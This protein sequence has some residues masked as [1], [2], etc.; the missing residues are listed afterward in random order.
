MIDKRIGR[1]LLAVFS[2][3]AASLAAA[4]PPAE[5]LAAELRR[6][7]AGFDAAVG[8]A[9]ILDGRDTVVIGGAADYP[10][11]SVVK[12]PQAMAVVD[13]L[14][15]SGQPLAT[16]LRIAPEEL[17]PDTWSPLRDSLPQ[18]GTMTVAELL[19]FTLQRSDNNACDILFDRF[20]GPEAV[21]RYLR[22]LGIGGDFAV[23]VTEAGMHRDPAAC[24]RNRTSPLAAAAW[25]ECLLTRKLFTPAGRRFLVETLFG[26]RTGADRLPQPL[27][28]TGARIGHK[29][30]TGD[31]RPDGRMIGCND[32]GFVVLPDGRHYTIAVLIRDSAESDAANARLIAEI[33]AIVYRYAAEHPRRC[34]GGRKKSIG[35]RPKK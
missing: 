29:T 18:G 5:R 22:G 7:T 14:E 1:L 21:D 34:G 27:A 15:R 3:A 19:R 23:A 35:N 28:D 32:V 20:G 25:T 4:C 26:C 31:R 16:P 8:V 2:L 24:Y 13:T 12:L 9:V 10:M 33:S 6:A 11:M 17:L 30:G